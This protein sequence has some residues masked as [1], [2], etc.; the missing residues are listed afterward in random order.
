MT[1]DDITTIKVSRDTWKELNREK[2]PG[3]SFDDVLRRLLAE[4]LEDDAGK[5][6]ELAT[7]D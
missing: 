1:D 2:E 5:P 7:S 3:D 6:D 4:R